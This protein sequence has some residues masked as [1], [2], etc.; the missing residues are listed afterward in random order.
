MSTDLDLTAAEWIRS[1]YSDANGGQCVEFSRTFAQT[2]DTI[3]VRDSKAPDGPTLIVSATG[4]SL[5]ISTL[6]RGEFRAA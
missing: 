4:W 2:H 5:F 3:P 1:S 6:I